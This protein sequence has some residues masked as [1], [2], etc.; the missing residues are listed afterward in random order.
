MKKLTTF[1]PLV[2]SLF[3]SIPMTTQG[4]SLEDWNPYAQ[5]PGIMQKMEKDSQ[6]QCLI[7]QSIGFPGNSAWVQ[8]FKVQDKTYYRFHAEIRITD[9]ELP[10]RSVVSKIDWKDA[11]GNRI[12]K[13]DYP[14]TQDSSTEDLLIHEGIYQAPEGA[15]GARLELIFRWANQGQV[16]WSNITFTSCNP[17]QPRTVKLASVNFRPKNSSSQGNHVKEFIPFLEKAGQSHADIVCLGEGI[18]VVG[19]NQKYVD[20]SETVPG[21]TTRLLGEI[22]QKYKMYIVAG[23][24]ERMGEIVYNTAVLLGRDG[25]LV[26][27]YRKTA[28]PREE[29]EGGITPGES[30]PVF[31]TDFGK[32]GMMICW[33]VQFPE[34]ARRLAMNG[35]EVILVPIW[36]GNETL[37]AARSIENQIY[38]V[39]SGYD[40]PTLILDHRGQRIGEAKE[41]GEITYATVD[42]NQRTF[43]D[44]LGDLK[45]RIPREAPL[46]REE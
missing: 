25:Q 43:W 41:N 46:T 22:A 12:S 4:A 42:L 34:P 20:V 31:Q 15:V 33:D 9:V 10:R 38:L 17:P 30:F 32:V 29:I 36:G 26:G 16:E 11:A 44:W 39:T 1:F 24:Y 21:P 45:A 2:L 8:N 3:L 23:I 28:L 27:T 37:M 14:R 35:A 18:T 5:R 13:P 6:K 40:A 7:Q 19:T